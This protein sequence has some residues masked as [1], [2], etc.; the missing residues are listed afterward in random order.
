L[1][2]RTTPGNLLARCLGDPAVGI[3]SRA[4]LL[5]WR[6]NLARLVPDISVDDLAVKPTSVIGELA[7]QITERLASVRRQAL[8]APTVMAAGAVA[9][10]RKAVEHRWGRMFAS[11]CSH[12][13]L[14]RL[15]A[16]SRESF[17]AV[18]T[19]APVVVLEFADPPPTTLP[20]GVV[21]RERRVAAMSDA[22]YKVVSPVCMAIE[23]AAGAPVVQICWLNST[24][25]VSGQLQ[26]VAAVADHR[27]L[28]LVD[29]PRTLRREMNIAG[30]TVGAPAARQ[31]LD[32][33]GAGVR[34]AVIDGE[35]NVTHR[36]ARHSRRRNPGCRGCDVRWRGARSDDPELQGVSDRKPGW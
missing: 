23:R 11:K 36:S 4:K 27:D 8:S 28:E 22:F 16:A 10:A 1:P 5:A 7:S 18:G 26:T 15:T 17:A 14:R 3:R 9:E 21:T 35:V 29:V 6:A 31:R 19:P 12:R 34:V 25:R 32:V 20:A 24:L 33:D 2:I 30:M 13:L